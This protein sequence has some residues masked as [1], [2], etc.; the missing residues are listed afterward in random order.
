[1]TA[2]LS[3]HPGVDIVCRDGSAAYAEAIRDGAPKAVLVSDRWHLWHGLGGAGGED[4]HRPEHLLARHAAA[5]TGA[6]D[7]GADPSSTRGR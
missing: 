1:L 2:W 4:R 7:L 5:R 6:A 3:E